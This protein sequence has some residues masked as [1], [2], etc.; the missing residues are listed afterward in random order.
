MVADQLYLG[1]IITMDERR[2]D[3]KKQKLFQA[4]TV[5]D[6]YVQYVGSE[7]MAR[8]LCDENTEVHDYRGS[9]IYPGM[10][11]AHCHPDMAGS[12]LKLCASLIGTN[13]LSE[14]VDIMKEYIKENP[15]NLFYVGAG[16]IFREEMPDRHM[17]DAICSDKPV[18]LNS[19]DGHSLWMNTKAL[20]INGIDREAA[21]EY[22]PDIVR[23]DENGE[24]TGYISEGPTQNI[25]A[26]VEFT[27][28]EYD[29]SLLAWQQKAF[30][31]GYTA[32]V[33]TGTAK[34]EI[35]RSYARLIESGQWKLRTYAYHILDENDPDYITRLEEMKEFADEYNC[36]YFEL[37]GPK[38][39]MDGVVEAHTAWM[40]DDY[41]DQPG[42]RGIKRM[43]DPKQFTEILV[44]AEELGLTVHCHTIGDGAIKFALDCIEEAQVKTGNFAM[45]T[46]LAHLQNIRP[47]DIRRFA[48]LNVV[49]V[50]PPLWTPRLSPFAEQEAYYIGANKMWA[51]YPMQSIADKGGVL[52]FH[53]D[54]PV[55]SE[56]NVPK[57]IFTAIT[58][59]EPGQNRENVPLLKESECL[60]RSQALTGLTA[61]PAYSVFQ[62]YWLG[63]LEIGFVA[64]MSIYDTD[65]LNAEED[66]IVNAKLIATV[67]DGE[68]V[69]KA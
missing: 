55:S 10:I 63:K 8:K 54:Y 27:D 59:R 4:L 13:D 52:A 17:L 20:E 41:L 6:G 38:V 21:K 40:L 46:A 23:V 32:C 45:R 47:E 11:E 15:D 26:S 2:L 36:E 1:N 28:A 37:M 14:C 34:P 50:V 60:T 49:A 9:Y 30:E 7:E 22:G 31:N 51:N 24:P 16:W 19:E 58:R 64:N 29:K 3:E 44:K 56:F 48:D 61:G 42:Y 12:R 68:E 43:S 53:S 62:E 66:E 39:F 65:F 33:H 18:M 57:T 25:L 5:K 69:Y 35:Y 67:V